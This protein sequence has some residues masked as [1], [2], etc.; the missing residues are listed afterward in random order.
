[1]D[2]NTGPTTRW[3]DNTYIGWQS[4]P[5]SCWTAIQVL[6][7]VGR[8]PRASTYV[9][10][11]PSP[12]LTRWTDT[13]IHGRKP[14]LMDGNTRPHLPGWQS[15]VSPSTDSNP[16]PPHDIWMAIQVLPP[17][18]F[19]P[20]MTDGNPC[21]PHVVDSNHQGFLHSWQSKSSSC[22]GQQY[23]SSTYDGRQSCSSTSDGWQSKSS[24]DGWQYRS[25]TYNGWV[26]H[27]RRTAIPVLLMHG[28]TVLP[29]GMAIQIIMMI[30][31]PHAVGPKFLPVSDGNQ[32]QSKSS[33]CCGRQYRSSTYDGRQSCSSTHDGRQSKSSSCC[34]RQYRSSTYDGRHP[35]SSTYA[36]MGMS[37]IASAMTLV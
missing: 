24:D 30:Q 3:M 10:R 22:C 28:N 17:L 27:S 15:L 36:P 16:S 20:L 33:S 35:K 8:N 13:Q 1:M 26:L 4:W 2:G 14:Q 21:P 37:V 12:P 31:V 6:P 18:L 29:Y 25:A 32:R 9:G 5:Y 7:Y 19:S 23:R 11:H 34:G